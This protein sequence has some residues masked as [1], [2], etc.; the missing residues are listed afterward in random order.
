MIV[1]RP[2]GIRDFQWAAALSQAPK[3]C[4]EV[5]ETVGQAAEV[6]EGTVTD[7]YLPRR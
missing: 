4:V 5:R 7:L 1:E 2:R 6:F 3:L